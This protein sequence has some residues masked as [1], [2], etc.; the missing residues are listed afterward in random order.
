MKVFRFRISSEELVTYLDPMCIFCKRKRSEINKIVD[1]KGTKA[2][3]GINIL[4]ISGVC[5]PVCDD[6]LNKKTK[7]SP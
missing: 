1:F 2:W 3:G 6:C 7:F 4:Q 5:K